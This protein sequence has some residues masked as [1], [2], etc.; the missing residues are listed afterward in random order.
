MPCSTVWFCLSN[1]TK[2]SSETSFQTT[3]PVFID[4]AL[5]QV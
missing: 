2:R 4:L 1:Q 5:V 3:F